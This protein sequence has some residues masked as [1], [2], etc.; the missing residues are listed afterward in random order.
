MRRQIDH[1]LLFLAAAPALPPPLESS[2][3]VHI[4]DINATFSISWQD[5]LEQ[6]LCDSTAFV[7]LGNL[8]NAVLVDAAEQSISV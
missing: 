7:V 5:P 4:V 2:S 3:D 6:Q 8:L 1:D